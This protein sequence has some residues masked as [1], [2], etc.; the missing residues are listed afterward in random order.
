M[1]TWRWKERESSLRRFK[2]LHELR[3]QREEA[4]FPDPVIFERDQTTRYKKKEKR[5]S[6]RPVAKPEI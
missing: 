1:T 4:H 6:S 5:K 2:I 3:D